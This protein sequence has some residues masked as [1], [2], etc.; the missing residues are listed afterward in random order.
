MKPAWKVSLLSFLFTFLVLLVISGVY[1][2]TSGKDPNKAGEEM[3]EKLAIFVILAPL[4]GY[5]VQKTRLDSANK[6]PPP[7]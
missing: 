2:A 3:G 7:S 4:V 6:K 5:I 1:A